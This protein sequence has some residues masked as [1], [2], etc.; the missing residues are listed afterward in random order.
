MNSI[1]TVPLTTTDGRK[2]SLTPL[3]LKTVRNAGK[4]VEVLT[5][6]GETY[7]FPISRYLFDLMMTVDLRGTGNSVKLAPK[8]S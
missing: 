5:H 6:S 2:V 8:I 3:D 1:Q 7:Q 4:G